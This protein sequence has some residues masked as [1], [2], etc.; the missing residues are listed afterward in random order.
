MA[1]IVLAA[2]LAICLVPLADDTEAVYYDIDGDLVI[3][4]EDEAEYR[5]TYTNNDYSGYQDVSMSIS[6]EAEL[7]DSSG[8]VVSDGVSPSSGSLDSGISETLTVTAPDEAGTYTL[9]VHYTVEVTYVDDDGE[10]VEVDDDR[11]DSVTISVVE[12]IALS[13]TL[14]NSSSADLTFGVYF[15]V[16]GEIIEDSYTLVSVAAGASSTVSYEWITTAGAGTYTYYVLGADS[17]NVVDVTG[18]GEERTFYIGDNSYTVW[19][20]LLV[21]LIIILALVMIWVY[22]KPVKNYGKPKSRR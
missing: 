8:N 1:G 3:G 14:T 15:Y 18:L 12:P 10:T 6:Y 2:M 11:D 21:I 16:N 19:I 17:G 22:R 7:V 9:R 20:V 5:I 4:V 13:V